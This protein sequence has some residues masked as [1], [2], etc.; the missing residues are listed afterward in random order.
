MFYE[1]EFS[2]EVVNAHYRDELVRDTNL[3]GSGLSQT[4]RF[5]NALRY[6]DFKDKEV[7]EV[8]C[9]K[10]DFLFYLHQR[11]QA[12]SFYRGLDPLEEMVQAAIE[13]VQGK[14]S[15]ICLVCEDY[16]KIAN[17]EGD[18]VVAFSVFDKKF[19]NFSVS[20]PYMERM[21]EKMIYDAH[22]G[23]Y[24]TFLSAFKII[25]DPTEALFYPQEIFEFAHRLSERV[26]IDHSYMPNVFSLIVYNQ[27]SP[28]RSEWGF[29]TQ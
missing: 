28:W 18:I 2:Q 6:F 11:N 15:D 3:Y 27:D 26:V 16:L 9:G 23:I 17:M 1:P 5:R 19:G 22:E 4:E 24:V 10:A 29:R 7:L 21:V 13:C 25:D 12:P 20:K 8:G 14:V